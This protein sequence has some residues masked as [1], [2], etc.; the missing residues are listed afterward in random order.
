MHAP[1]RDETVVDRPVFEASTSQ[2]RPKERGVRPPGRP[3]CRPP[4]SL[5]AA[6]CLTP[7][8]GFRRE[9]SDTRRR[10]SAWRTPPGG[11]GQIRLITSAAA[12]R[13]FGA[14]AYLSSGER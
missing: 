5:F 13:T 11:I 8:G 14:S 10:S 7:G 9:V 2:P 3:P 6:K 1:D 4:P 12:K